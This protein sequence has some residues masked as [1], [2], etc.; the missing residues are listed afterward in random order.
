MYGFDLGIIL[1]NRV[2]HVLGPCCGI[3]TGRTGGHVN[4]WHQGENDAADCDAGK[5]RTDRFDAK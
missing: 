2:G 5:D 1:G 3:G 4:S